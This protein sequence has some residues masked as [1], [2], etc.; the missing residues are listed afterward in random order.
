[1]L[2]YALH[3]TIRVYIR[4]PVIYGTLFASSRAPVWFAHIIWLMNNVFVGI[5]YSRICWFAR[6]LI[7]DRIEIDCL[8]YYSNM[9]MIRAT[10]ARRQNKRACA[11][12]K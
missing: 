11:Q 3:N 2:V 8:K 6:Y 12:S 7:N 1:M 4:S 5:F 9:H 10:P